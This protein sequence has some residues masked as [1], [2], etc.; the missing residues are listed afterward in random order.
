MQSL[1][2]T[3]EAVY[4]LFITKHQVE[5]ECIKLVK[6]IYGS[7]DS[8]LKWQKCFVKA[9]TG[10]DGETNCEQSQIDLWKWRKNK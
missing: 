2:H 6:S 9:C 3:S 7:V 8:A 1:K 4:E 5:N 10:P